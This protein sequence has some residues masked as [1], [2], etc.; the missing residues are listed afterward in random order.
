MS[1]APVA[2]MGFGAVRHTR[3][4]PARNAF[5]YP[6]YFLMLP[7][8]SLGLHGAGELARNR[9]AAI[10]F[11]DKDHGDG[12]ADAMQWIDDLLKSEG[13]DDAKGEA[14]LHCYPRVFGYSFKP[15]SFW[16]CHRE[17]GS[18]RA[19]VVEVNNTFGERHVYLLDHAKYGHEM[20]ATKVFHVSPFCNVEGQYRFRFMT[21]AKN[22]RTVARIDYDDANG[23]LINTSVSGDLQALNSQA[24]RKALLSYGAM[25]L[26]VIARIHWQALKLFLKRVP[27]FSK[28]KPP[29]VLVTR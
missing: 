12:R 16:Y 7:M 28:P 4:R 29:A 10:S 24:I 26:G 20:K 23:A 8:R 11:H 6:T 15:V 27:F 1:A 9:A 5:A 2:M 22:A 17:D 3:L 14:W 21:T 19:V 18:L 13:I 25:T